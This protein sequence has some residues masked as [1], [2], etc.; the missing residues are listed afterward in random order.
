M[1]FLHCA[2]VA[3]GP[4]VS[5]RWAA[6]ASGRI[7]A[8][9]M[10][11]DDGYWQK[12]SERESERTASFQRDLDEFLERERIYIGHVQALQAEITEL[13]ML[14]AEAT[15]PAAPAVLLPMAAAPGEAMLS[16][17]EKERDA[18]GEQLE[19]T[20]LAREVDVQRTGAFWLERLARQSAT[21]AAAAGLQE[22]LEASRR[23]LSAA[24]MAREVDIQKVAAFWV[25]KLASERE[26]A[27]KATAFWVAAAER[28]A[29]ALTEAISAAAAA[30]SAPSS[31]AIMAEA[32]AAAA[33]AAA[34]PTV[35]AAVGSSDKSREERLQALV[36]SLEA[37]VAGLEEDYEDI[38]ERLMVQSETMTMASARLD[39]LADA[40]EDQALKAEQQLQRAAAFWVAK[41]A[42]VRAQHAALLAASEANASAQRSLADDR[43][44]QL[45][46]V[47]PAAASG[48]SSAVVSAS[49]AA[50]ATPSASAA[51]DR[52][53]ELEAFVELQ[54]EMIE[55]QEARLEEAALQREADVQ[56]V[57]A[58]WVAKTA[59]L[60]SELKAMSS[61]TSAMQQAL[62]ARELR[63]ERELQA[64]AAFW[65]QR[66]ASLRERV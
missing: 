64:T 65:L 66:V 25:A 22:E 4:S 42:D 1:L 18:L 61:Q 35:A 5:S 41:L 14:R 9:H 40:L 2:L 56:T 37:E 46:A 60:Q 44:R 51:G 15:A 34:T 30:N 13:R 54:S 26:A 16:E 28:E 6:P 38:S 53:R 58:F 21:V 32:S 62:S 33:A 55:L 52:V 3:F 20:K 57:A 45:G 47:A 49:P 11:F 31:E 48:T 24:Q 36:E 23:A 59:D 39:E 12:R 50:S 63:A 19:A 7:P 10:S 43:L 27:T 17:L 29:T 8:P